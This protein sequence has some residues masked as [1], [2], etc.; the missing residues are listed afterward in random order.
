MDIDKE[1]KLRYLLTKLAR[2]AD[3]LP[4]TGS[5]LEEAI[6]EARYE[7]LERSRR[8]TCPH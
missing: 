7:L 8:V 6:S 5:K 1:V 3:L 2:S 4:N